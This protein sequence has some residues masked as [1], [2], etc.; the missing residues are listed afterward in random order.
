MKEGI[1]CWVMCI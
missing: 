1:K